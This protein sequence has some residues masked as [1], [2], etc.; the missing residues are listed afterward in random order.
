MFREMISWM[1][2]FTSNSEILKNIQKKNERNQMMKQA[3]NN[4]IDG[5]NN[6]K[7]KQ[8]L[9]NSK[10]KKKDDNIF[11]YLMNLADKNGFYDHLLQIILYSFD[12]SLGSS[13]AREILKEW[14]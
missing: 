10:K 14:C 9:I 8:L 13:P 6:D 4:N 5:P 3:S 7:A 1:G 11:Y 2:L 12:F